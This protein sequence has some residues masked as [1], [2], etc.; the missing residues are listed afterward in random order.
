MFAGA[1]RRFF[2]L[3]IFILLTL[4]DYQPRIYKPNF[5]IKDRRRVI[6]GPL[7]ITKPKIPRAL[8]RTPQTSR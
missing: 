8:F 5:E 7:K 6:V 3:R 4:K 2:Q 1:Y